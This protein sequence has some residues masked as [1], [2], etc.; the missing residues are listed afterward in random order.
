[1]RFMKDQRPSPFLDSDP[2][3]AIQHIPQP[4][5]R[6][7][8]VPTVPRC[9]PKLAWYSFYRHRRYERLSEHFTA[10]SRPAAW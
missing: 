1:M 4:G 5:S 3:G 6:S 2:R 7:N 10:G 9:I 8:A